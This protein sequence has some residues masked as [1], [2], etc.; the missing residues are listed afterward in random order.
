MADQTQQARPAA[1]IELHE[2]KLRLLTEYQTLTE[3][4][5]QLLQ[6]EDVEGFEA[7][8]A[9]R[10]DLITSIDALQQVVEELEQGEPG[11]EDARIGQLRQ[12]QLQI[13]SAIRTLDAAHHAQ[14]EQQ[15]TRFGAEAKHMTLSKKGIGAYNQAF[16]PGQS[17]L[18]D[19]KQ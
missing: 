4:Q 14:A 13:L 10:R 15:L 9:G 5:G 12:A 1:L 11:P 19:K 18:F 8:L 3:A 2:Q 17:E 6:A 7:N 16:A